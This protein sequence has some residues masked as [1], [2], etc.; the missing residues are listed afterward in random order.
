MSQPA[1]EYGALPFDDNE[2]EHG[3]QTVKH[4]ALI[5]Q[6]EEGKGDSEER[7]E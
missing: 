3:A 7:Q 6:D 1:V 4:G 2:E 5:M